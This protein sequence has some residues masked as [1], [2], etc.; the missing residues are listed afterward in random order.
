M[1]IATRGRM[2]SCWTPPPLDEQP[3]A[4]NRT[5]LSGTIS[6][7]EALTYNM[8]LPVSTSIIGVDSVEQIEENVK[9]A[10]DFTPLSLAQ[11][12]EIE[13]KTLSY[14]FV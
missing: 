7:K 14:N 6:I 13:I 11:M 1:K 4:R 3:D 10:S 12:E 8:S 2:L 5:P 9:I